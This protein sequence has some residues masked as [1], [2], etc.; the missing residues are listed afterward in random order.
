MTRPMLNESQI[1]DILD[2]IFRCMNKV[3][4][5]TA[6][7]NQD[8][9]H[10]TLVIDKVARTMVALQRTVA[11]IWQAECLEQCMKQ[12]EDRILNSRFLIK[13]APLKLFEH[14]KVAQGNALGQVMQQPPNVQ[15]QVV[16]P[17]LPQP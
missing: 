16:F 3:Q 6:I 8:Y 17:A 9:T 2:M 11:K 1:N 15:S 7:K 4:E 14:I 10:M 5:V 13:N 12:L